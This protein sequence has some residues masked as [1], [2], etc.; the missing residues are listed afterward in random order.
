M[1]IFNK[2]SIF[3][4]KLLWLSLRSFRAKRALHKLNKKYVLKLTNDEIRFIVDSAYFD[5]EE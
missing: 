5:L 4:K 2:E 3:D 1:K